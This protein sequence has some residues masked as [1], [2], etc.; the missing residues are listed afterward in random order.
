MIKVATSNYLKFGG[1][2][3]YKFIFSKTH[4]AEIQNQG[5]W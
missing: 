4:R 1:F 5:G 2:Y 3:P